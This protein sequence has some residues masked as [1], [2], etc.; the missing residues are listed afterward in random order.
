[1]LTIEQA[2]NIL[3]LLSSLEPKLRI[4]IS[5]SSDDDIQKA[6]SILKGYNLVLEQT[7]W[8][9]KEINILDVKE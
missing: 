1:M 6:I 7:V 2:T 5:F 9:N 8:N 3:S 4:C